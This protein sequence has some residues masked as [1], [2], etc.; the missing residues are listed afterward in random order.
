MLLPVLIINLIVAI[1][2]IIATIKNYEK[3]KR[4]L[5]LNI[6]EKYEDSFRS[7]MFFLFFS[8]Y[9]TPAGLI[10]YYFHMQEKSEFIGVL[11]LGTIIMLVYLVL[12]YRSELTRHYIFIFRSLFVMYV[13]WLLVDISNLNTNDI[14]AIAYKHIEFLLVMI[15]GLFAYYPFKKYYVLVG[16][17]FITFLGFSFYYGIDIK[18]KIILFLDLI[19]LLGISY[20]RDLS[21]NNISINYYRSL[22]LVDTKHIYVVS[23]SPYGLIEYTN[24]AF[25]KLFGTLSEIQKNTW[26]QFF[27]NGY[28][29]NNVTNHVLKNG[30]ELYLEWQEGEKIVDNT[31]FYSRNINKRHKLEVDLINSKKWLQML[32]KNTGDFL[33][34]IDSNLIIKDCFY[35]AKY[36]RIAKM[37]SILNKSIKRI[38][39]PKRFQ[40]SKNWYDTLE[41]KIILASKTMTDINYTAESIDNS[42]T[43]HTIKISL[44]NT[45]ERLSPDFLIVFTVIDKI[46]NEEI[47]LN[48]NSIYNKIIENLPV[49]IYCKNENNQLQFVNDKFAA[50]YGK[51]EYELKNINEDKIEPKNDR[52]YFEYELE[53]LKLHNGT[54]ITEDVRINQENRQEYFE[55]TKILIN[56]E[57]GGNLILGI[58]HNITIQKE[59]EKENTRN[60]EIQ[61]RSSFSKDLKITN[62]L[63]TISLA[64]EYIDELINNEKNV[65]TIQLMQ[66]RRK[67]SEAIVEE[68]SVWKDFKI[69]FEQTNPKL[70]ASLSKICPNLSKN[71]LKHCAYIIANL[72][73]KSVSKMLNTSVRGIHTT[74]YRIK[75]K[76]NLTTED[77]LYEYLKVLNE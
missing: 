38:A 11:I 67:L 50:F 42:M 15:I 72:N 43:Y 30:K 10:T 31:L 36:N 12:L 53:Q 73:A 20:I 44:I 27:S 2:S 39:V 1:F 3:L 71:E 77:N 62:Y 32:I 18:W 16:L 37:E 46:K 69:S 7:F 6:E 23:V 5:Q 58:L 75:K 45:S 8:F 54:Y 34:I 74:R 51:K 28:I 40:I 4:N 59:I 33:I 70:F 55:A 26:E 47:N 21:E 19:V 13:S 29:G 52:D 35:A 22:N 61:Q 9:L 68:E 65:S 48:N 56:L 60:L 63:N 24:P 14:M 17:F 41:E 64:T 66:I 76:L 57:N 49:L 25:E